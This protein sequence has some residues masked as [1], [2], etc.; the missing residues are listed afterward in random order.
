MV[1]K[2]GENITVYVVGV[3]YM[4]FSFTEALFQHGNSIGYD[5]D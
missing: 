1:Q 2:S 3:R 5:V 4:R